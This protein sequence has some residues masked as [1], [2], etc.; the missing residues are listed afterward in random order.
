[1]P[2]DCDNVLLYYYYHYYHYYQLYPV[3]DV[4]TPTFFGLPCFLVRAIQ[5]CGTAFLQ[6]MDWTPVTDG[7]SRD[8]EKGMS[9]WPADFEV[10]GLHVRRV[11][12]VV[13][14]NHRCHW[15]IFVWH[16][17]TAITSANGL[18]HLTISQHMRTIRYV[19]YSGRQQQTSLCVDKLHVHC[20]SL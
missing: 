4:V 7:A 14:S 18:Q 9:W 15:S 17:T 5:H 8:L 12:L 19:G 20:R 11:S 13:G 1:V 10:I 3:F 6:Q 16:P 2:N